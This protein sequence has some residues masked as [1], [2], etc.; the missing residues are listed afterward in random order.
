MSNAELHR[1]KVNL[2]EYDGRV[3][4]YV[5]VR[6][7]FAPHWL[8]PAPQNCAASIHTNICRNQKSDEHI[9]STFWSSQTTHQHNY[10]RECEDLRVLPPHPAAHGTRAAAEGGRLAS[11]CVCLVDEE[12]DAL[13]TREDLLNILDHDVL[14]LVQLRLCSR[15]FVCRW[16]RVVRMHELRDRW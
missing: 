13:A 7:H 16:G 8:R 10:A 11:H 15:E 6:G 2:P 14:D 1:Y 9:L 5:G 4:G 12:L 3:W